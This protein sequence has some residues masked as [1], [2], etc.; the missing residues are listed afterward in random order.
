MDNFVEL[1]LSKVPNTAA[2][3]NIAILIESGFACSKSKLVA[4]GVLHLRPFNIG[5]SG[6]LDLSNTY[7]IPGNMVPA[8]KS[9]VQAGDILFNNTNSI[10]IVGKSAFICEDL[11]AGFSNHMTRIRLD[12]SRCDPL[13]VAAYLRRLWSKG[14]FRSQCT[15]WV[16]QAAYGLRLLAKLP[17]PLPSLEEQRRIAR[18]LNQALHIEQLHL[19]AAATASALS[20]SLVDRLLGD[21]Q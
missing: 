3:D 5:Q 1:P 12:R 21:S 11:D 9:F 17:I 18:I 4:N 13:Y 10:E 14:Y 2:L 7:R 15:Q 16:S 19:R 6:R 8:T 20:A